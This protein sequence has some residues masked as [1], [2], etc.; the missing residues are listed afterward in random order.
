MH[1]NPSGRHRNIPVIHVELR[2]VYTVSVLDVQT[3]P[4]I[5]SS[6]RHG[7]TPAQTP[8]HTA[9]PSACRQ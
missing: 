4:H 6:R 8:A 7:R 3:T 9:L 2:T 1:T 5:N